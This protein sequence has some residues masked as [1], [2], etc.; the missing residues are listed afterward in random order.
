MTWLLCDYGEVLSLPP[1]LEDRAALAATAGWEPAR[2]DFWE[3]YWADRIAYDRG[4]VT[5]GVFWEAM[6]G[7]QPDPSSLDRIVA[8]DVAMWLHP[9]VESVAAAQ[10]AAERGLRL[11]ILSNAPVEVADGIDAA[12]WL[13]PFTRRFFSCR[14][15]SVKPEPAV[16]KAVL[17]ALGAEPGEIFFFDDRPA[18]VAGARAAG[19]R[20]EV[21]SGPADLDGVKPPE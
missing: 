11:A 7:R 5:A 3:A 18:N 15:R 20:A 12:P 16:Y 17:E 10:R 2:G 14:I 13:A 6:I 8:R 1:T 9:N 19:I 4:D 21:W